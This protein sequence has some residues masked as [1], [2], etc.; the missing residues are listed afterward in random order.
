MNII[1]ELRAIIARFDQEGVD[2]ALCGELAMA[3]YAMPRATLDIDLLIQ[4]DALARAQTAVEPLG[5]R[6]G[7]RLKV[8]SPQGLI[9]LKSFRRSGTDED[10][11]A[12]LR[13]II[14]ED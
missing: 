11:I 7:K 13:S 12:H 6:E 5:F 1:D 10:D 14:D 2:Y 4:V 3:I 8:V 9:L